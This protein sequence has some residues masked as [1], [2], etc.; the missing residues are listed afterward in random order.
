MLEQGQETFDI[1]FDD[2]LELTQKSKHR[3]IN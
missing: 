2:E 1:E 3:Q